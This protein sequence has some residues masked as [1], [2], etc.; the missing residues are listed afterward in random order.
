MIYFFNLTYIKNR[1]YTW[2]TPNKYMISLKTN[3]EPRGTHR[4]TQ[5]GTHPLYVVHINFNLDTHTTVSQQ[6]AS[7]PQSLRFM[8][9]LHTFVFPY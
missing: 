9:L 3:R 4:G 1:W 2:Y 7:P 6:L 5:A 8:L